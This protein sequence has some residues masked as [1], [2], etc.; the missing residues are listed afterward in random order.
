MNKWIV[1][2]NKIYETHEHYMPDEVYNCINNVDIRHYPDIEFTI[3]MV[4]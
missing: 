4:E 3:E 2:F 1:S